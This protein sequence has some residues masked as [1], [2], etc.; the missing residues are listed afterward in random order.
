MTNKELQEYLIKRFPIENEQWEWKEFSHLKHAV[1]GNEGEDKVEYLKKQGKTSRKAIDKLILPKLSAALTE[2]Q[3]KNK[4][5]KF[6]VGITYSGKYQK[7][8]GIFLGN[9]LATF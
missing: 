7:F 4:V 3:K 8:T 2:E 6:S 5:K 9:S 1:K